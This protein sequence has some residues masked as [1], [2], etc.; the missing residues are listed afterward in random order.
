MTC[1]NLPPRI[2]FEPPYPP[3]T[4]I[5]VADS[6]E[7]DDP[8]VLKAKRRR[9]QD[10]ADRYI[11]GQPLYIHSA[12]LKGPFEPPWVNP[13]RRSKKRLKAGDHVTLGRRNNVVDDSPQ[14]RPG[15]QTPL[16]RRPDDSVRNGPHSRKQDGDFTEAKK[17]RQT[18]TVDGATSKFA[19]ARQSKLH[20]RER[21]RRPPSP[22]RKRDAAWMEAGAQGSFSGNDNQI[23]SLISSTKSKLPEKAI[24]RK[25]L[26]TKLSQ[27]EV[28]PFP[29]GTQSSESSTLRQES[30]SSPQIPNQPRHVHYFNKGR[31]SKERC[32]VGQDPDHAQPRQV[33]SPSPRVLVP[34]TDNY[35]FKSRRAKHAVDD[36]PHS[37]EKAPALVPQLSSPS[38]IL[39]EKI[40]SQINADAVHHHSSPRLQSA[41]FT[42]D[43]PQVSTHAALDDTRKSLQAIIETPQERTVGGQGPET[44]ETASS[45]KEEHA[46]NRV[47]DSTPRQDIGSCTQALLA[48]LSPLAVTTSGKRLVSRGLRP[49]SCTPS[50]CARREVRIAGDHAEDQSEHGELASDKSGWLSQKKPRDQSDTILRSALK[51][52]R[53]GVQG[54][55]SEHFLNTNEENEIA[56]IMDDVADNLLESWD[57]ETEVR[58]LSC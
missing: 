56:A 16:H 53:S 57:I 22:R 47:R 17:S 41:K 2:Q 13:W 54:N 34:N 9:I 7:E 50:P 14:V 32:L 45:G 39:V 5:I 18:R 11:A 21:K 29:G 6:D 51:Q 26:P 31:P 46:Q 24:A 20:L 12:T 48:Q 35:S 38:R 49:T 19:T 15:K 58:K 40:S 44:R 3:P 36:S 28:S 43:A 37:R 1:V 52:T 33:P 55:E 23:S 4:D 42:A 8:A 27:T 30:F 25:S 10:L